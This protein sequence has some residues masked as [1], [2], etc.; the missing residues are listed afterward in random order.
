MEKYIELGQT[1]A[2][3]F[4]TLFRP[5]YLAGDAPE[6][7]DSTKRIFLRNERKD[8]AVNGELTMVSWNILR[9]YH[10]EKV[11]KTL[12]GILE[13]QEPGL[14]LVQEAPVYDSS[15]FWDDDIFREF[16]AYYAPLHQVKKQTAFY[17]FAHSGQLTLS[18]YPF[19][20]T[21]V[22]QLPSVS[23]PVLTKNHVIKRLALYTQVQ[24]EGG[25]TIGIYNVHLENAT[26]Q[27]GRRKQLEYLLGIIEKNGD[28][29]V[30]VGGDFNTFLGGLEQGI[31]TL[32][33]AGFD[34]LLSRP[35]VVPR[36][37]RFLV[38][39]TKARAVPLRGYG[40]DHQPI[41]VVLNI[42]NQP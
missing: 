5:V 27:T 16:N 19:T 36:L 1:V 2:G 25:K 41:G 23:K 40:S 24:M 30:V 22:Y 32:K 26:W 39:G 18:R 31:S 34:D 3:F 29:V 6:H 15:T 11:R 35:R 9:N 13:E 10:Q 21:E 33:K 7:Y 38:R 14:V 37:D 4:R 28:D 12:T 17:N 20:K 42:E 8:R